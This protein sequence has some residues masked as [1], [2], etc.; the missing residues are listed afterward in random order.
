MLTPE[1]LPW[2]LQLNDNPWIW[3][4]EYLFVYVIAS[5]VSKSAEQIWRSTRNLEMESKSVDFTYVKVIMAGPIEE[6]L[7]RG[8]AVLAAATVAAETSLVTEP[9]LRIVLLLIA[10]AVWAGYHQRAFGT[11]A[12]TFIFGFFLSQF[13]LMGASGP[14]WVA[15][16]FHSGHNAWVTWAGEQLDPKQSGAPAG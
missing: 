16:L 8:T 12:F 4:I 1:T 10:N 6:I 14:W 13:W 3:F 2:W 7:F 15:V 9:E 11:F 5:V